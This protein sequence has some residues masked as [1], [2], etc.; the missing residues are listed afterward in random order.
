MEMYLRIAADMIEGGSKKLGWIHHSEY[1]STA[2]KALCETMCHFIAGSWTSKNM[3][4]FIEECE[5]TIIEMKKIHK[6]TLE[7]EKKEERKK[8]TEEA[9]AE[10]DDEDED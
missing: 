10:E 8:Q 3:K 7:K 9:E 6:K 4:K 1:A 2:S 5:E